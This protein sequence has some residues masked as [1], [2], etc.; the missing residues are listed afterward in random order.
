MQSLIAYLLIILII[1]TTFI[2]YFYPF[3]AKV[4]CMH[5]ELVGGLI[6]GLNQ[7]NFNTL[8]DIFKSNEIK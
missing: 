6:L 4:I 5:T 7:E 2:F 3:Y 8:K 1:S